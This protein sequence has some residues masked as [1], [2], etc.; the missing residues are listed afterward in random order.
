MKTKTTKSFLGHWLYGAA[1]VTVFWVVLGGG[2]WV[3]KECC[4]GRAL[5]PLLM[6]LF[7]G[8]AFAIIKQCEPK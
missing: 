5:I 4:Q 3:V 8:L 6:V 7:G 1:V 2:L